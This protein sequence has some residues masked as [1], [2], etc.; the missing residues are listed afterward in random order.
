MSQS[1]QN[2][3]SPANTFTADYPSLFGDQGI[4]RCP[5]EALE[6]SF[7]P[8]AYAESL[9]GIV[10]RLETAVGTPPVKPL[11]YRR[12]DIPGLLL[13]EPALNRR[14][15][16]LSLVIECLEAMVEF[17]HPGDKKA[18]AVMAAATSP[19][20]LPF[21][22]AWALVI[23]VLRSKRQL[24]WQLLRQ[25][26]EDY[27]NFSHR[28]VVTTSMR[29]ALTLCTGLAPAQLQALQ[30]APAT[31]DNVLWSRLGLPADST[32]ETVAD[33]ATF[34]RATGLNRKRLRQLLAVNGVAPKDDSGT[35][36]SVTVSKTGNP[37]G[38][39]DSGAFGACF[40]NGGQSPALRLVAG[41][42]TS[43][44]TRIDNLSTGHLQRID[45][46]L[47]LHAGMGL[48]FA[49]IDRLLQAIFVAQ[50]R[51][52]DFQVDVHALRALGLY[53]H[54]RDSRQVNLDAYAAVID[55][56]SPYATGRDTPYYDK[57][58][59]SGAGGSDLAGTAAPLP[60]TTG[61]SR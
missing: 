57:L 11:A 48:S 36:T 5:D 56:I 24:P 53:C 39:A 52:E 7:G 21:D 12:P 22:R 6:S 4:D 49:A 32:V 41:S 14:V 2:S 46:M 18:A 43:K 47:R 20:N 37:G 16:R 33:S 45:A 42:A 59:H 34:L 19:A 40:V 1:L 25:T 60:W 54:L 31:D 38:L 10:R 13:D 55:E 35:Y 23:Q 51:D 26:D 61:R 17:T 3:P 58:F 29:N 30:L 28:A 44:T 15:P 50:D 9:I 8:F 27:P